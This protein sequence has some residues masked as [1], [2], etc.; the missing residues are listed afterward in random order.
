[1]PAITEADSGRNDP[2]PLAAQHPVCGRIEA[3]YSVYRDRNDC[4]A[5]VCAALP[6]EAA[7]LGLVT[8]DDPETSLWRPFGSRR[9]LHIRNHDSTADIRAR[10][11]RYALISE[12]TLQ[13][14]YQTTFAEWRVQRGAE[15][16]REFKLRLLAGRD[17]ESWFLLRWP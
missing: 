1:M 12:I 15:L 5:P 13:N 14:R 16:I 7:D 2:P 8:Y 17:P 10:G 3:V 9:I 6:A 11:I 4:F